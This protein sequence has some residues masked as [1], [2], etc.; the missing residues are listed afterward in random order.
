MQQRLQK[1]KQYPVILCGSLIYAGAVCIFYTGNNLP[2]GGVTGIAL[3]LHAFCRLPVGTLVLLFNIPI[4]YLGYKLFGGR[5]IVKTLFA[6]V[7][8]SLLIDFLPLFLPNYILALRFEPLLSALYGGLLSGLGLGLVFI[9]GATTGGGDIV[10]RIVNHYRPHL[11]LGRV[12]MVFDLLVIA[13]Y[14]LALRNIHASLYG[15][16]AMFV[17]A[18]VIDAILYGPDSAKMAYIITGHG[19]VIADGIMQNLGRGVTMLHGF[20]AG[21]KLER[22]ILMTAIKQ[23]QIGQLRVLVGQLDPAAFMIVLSVQE[24]FGSGF[25]EYIVKK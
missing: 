11:T 18:Q 3:I 13:A 17:S 4:L 6:T 2:T 24:V 10:S 12:I 15:I 8:S 19:Q 1:I 21:K 20:G 16:V 22:P 7:L 23:N 25:K 9:G 5:F 14:G